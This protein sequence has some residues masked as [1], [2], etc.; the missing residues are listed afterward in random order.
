MVTCAVWSVRSPRIG[1]SLFESAVVSLDRVVGVLLDVVPR[2]R[3]QLVEHAGVDRGGGGD[4]L[5]GCHLQR[6]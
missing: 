6:R 1:L 5:A 4:H 2:L 3:D